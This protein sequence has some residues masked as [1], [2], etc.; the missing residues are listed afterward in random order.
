MTTS[1]TELKAQS[2]VNLKIMLVPSKI[3]VYALQNETGADK[4]L[5]WLKREINFEVL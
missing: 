5:A 3:T 1:Y 2:N 4:L